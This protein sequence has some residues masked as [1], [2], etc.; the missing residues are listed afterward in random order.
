MEIVGRN[1]K[2][3]APTCAAEYFSVLYCNRR[4][5]VC[6]QNSRETTHA[7]KSLS[8]AEQKVFIDKF[9][10]WQAK[11]NK[12][13]TSILEHVEPFLKKKTTERKGNIPSNLNTTKEHCDISLPGSTLNISTNSHDHIQSN[14]DLEISK[15]EDL[16]VE[17]YMDDYDD[18]SESMMNLVYDDTP[19]GNLE[20]PKQFYTASVIDEDIDESTDP[21]ETNET[22]T[23]TAL[24]EPALPTVM[25]PKELFRIIK[26]SG[27][28]PELATVEWKTMPKKEKLMYGRAIS[29]IKKDYLKN[30][31]QYLESLSSPEL[32]KH[33]INFRKEN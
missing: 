33:Y 27:T 5:I 9:E 12:K 6:I 25:R 1:G 17:F 14:A 10:T 29:K 15:R 2:L 4:K 8:S 13:I 28:R 23:K 21:R 22:V 16:N 7:W 11:T 31:E 18:Q 19:T 30:Y 32:F 24:R 20:V 26:A 3:R